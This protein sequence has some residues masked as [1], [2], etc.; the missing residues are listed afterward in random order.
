MRIEKRLIQLFCCITTAVLLQ[1][2]AQDTL[3]S[4]WV[5]QSFKGPIKGRIVVVGIFKDP[6]AYNIFE[7]SF[8]ATL[9]KAGADAVPSHQYGQGYQRHSK[10]WLHQVVKESGAAAILITHLSNEKK[11]TENVAPHGLIL[12]GAMYGDGAEGYQSYMVEV[13]L[14]QGYTLN[15]T[16]DFIDVTIFDGQTNK[17]IWSARSKSVNLNQLLRKDDVQLENLYIS[18]MKRDRIL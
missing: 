16:E 18:N 3:T 1:S 8:V 4:S 10:E 17:P 6:T 13:T 7:E 14:E 5:D 11:E 12:G 15:R 2:C 9:V